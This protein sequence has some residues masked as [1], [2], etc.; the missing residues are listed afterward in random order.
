MLAAYIAGQCLHVYLIILVRSLLIKL[1]I[2]DSHAYENQLQQ[3]VSGELKAESNGVYPSTVVPNNDAKKEE[4][5]K[6]SALGC[7]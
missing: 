3:I 6:T 2:S 1:K 7:V 5:Q 4:N